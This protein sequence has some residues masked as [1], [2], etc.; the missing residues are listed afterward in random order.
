MRPN[1]RFNDA[2]EA[3]LVKWL[4]TVRGPN[5]K[6][7]IFV[8]LPRPQGA[9]DARR[10]HGIRVAARSKLATHDVAGDAQGRIWYS[11]H[12][13][14]YIGRLDPQDRRRQGVS[15]FRSRQRR[16]SRHA[17]DLR[18][19]GRRWC[20]A[21]RTGRTISSASI[22]RPKNSRA[23]RGR[24]RSRSTRRWAATTR[25]IPKA[26]S[27]SCATTRSSKVDGLDRRAGRELQDQEI[28]GHLWQRDE[29]ATAAI[30]AAAHGRATVSSCS[31]RRRARS[32]SRA[33]ARIR[34]R[35]AASSIS[36]AIIGRAGA[37]VSSSSST[38]RR[39]ASTNT[40]RRRPMRRSTAPSADKNGEVWAGEMHGGRYLALQSEDRRV[41]AICA[42]RALRHRPQ[43]LDRQFHRPRHASGMSTRKARSRASSRWN[44]GEA[45]VFG[46]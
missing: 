36:R 37:A 20:G 40:A 25:S 14:S 13:S 21:R 3:R 26:S 17:L 7:P 27:G 22:P 39:S 12:R 33:R 28:P 16:A 44:N 2:D 24:C 6:D 31:T 18:R 41:D 42:A 8:T 19:P 10:H 43:E 32:T 5:S 23:C 9:A 11:T 46:D 29:P 45:M 30:S 34:D 4:A 35:R 15:A 38:S 1:G